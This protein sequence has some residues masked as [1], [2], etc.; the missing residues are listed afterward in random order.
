[1]LAFLSGPL[2]ISEDFHEASSQA[3]VTGKRF[4]PPQKGLIPLQ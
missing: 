3:K 2:V 1:M 4:L